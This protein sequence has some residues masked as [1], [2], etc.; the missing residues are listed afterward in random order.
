MA[1]KDASRSPVRQSVKAPGDPGRPREAEPSVGRQ[2]PHATAPGDALCSVPAFP[3]RWF[4]TA[5]AELKTSGTMPNRID[6]S[7][8]RY[9]H[10][11]ATN[12][13]LKSAFRFLGLIGEDDAPTHECETL[14]KAFGDKNW[15]LQLSK[16]LKGAYP[17]VMGLGIERAS[18]AQ[19]FEL[20]RD[21]YK[22]RGAVARKAVTF[23]FHAAREA[24][25]PVGPF[26]SSTR[27]S[28]LKARQGSSPAETVAHEL[29]ARLPPFDPS[30]SE[31]M[32]V[33]WLSAFK[34]LAERTRD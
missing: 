3:F 33:A 31:D 16:V 13:E 1:A 14:I 28:P 25:L 27:R 7:L 29:L 15:S 4:R 5:I 12:K 26:I 10:F 8:W 20:F 11:G 6:R 24:E 30:W 32:K 9:K 19:I 22:V 17:E 34:E 21:R 23:F 18:P 2:S